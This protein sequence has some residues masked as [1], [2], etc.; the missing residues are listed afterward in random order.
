MN[1]RIA[2]RGGGPAAAAAAPARRP[3]VQPPAAERGASRR[4]TG[5]ERPRARRRPGLVGHARD[6]RGVEP[7][8][9]G[10]P[11]PAGSRLSARSPALCCSTSV[12]VVGA[13]RHAGPDAARAPRPLHA[14]A[15]MSDVWT[16]FGRNLLVL[17]LH[18]MACLAGFIAKSSL[19]RE[20]EGYS[21]S[22]RTV[23][24]HA[25][26]LAIAFVAGATL[27]SLATQ[28]YA[29]GSRLSTLADADGH[30]R[31]LRCCSALLA[32][33]AAG[34]RRALPPARRVAPRRARRRR[35]ISCSPRR[36]RRPRSRC[37]WCSPRRPSRCYVTP[38]VLRAL[39]FV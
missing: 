7:R 26:P 31:P 34:A 1:W 13:R 35:G 30:R 22:W 2:P 8:A 14:A 15:T 29:L 5:C 9:V 28:S 21:G 6:A 11:R 39:H 4:S 38:E 17:A 23:H 3:S 24:D 19:P 37:P 36:S 12:C 27:F 10:G 32:A 20:A 33:R 18:A 16:I 25:G